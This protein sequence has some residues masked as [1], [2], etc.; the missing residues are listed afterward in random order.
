MWHR[1]GSDLTDW[2]QVVREIPIRKKKKKEGGGSEVDTQ[3]AKRV[4]E[5][6]QMS[7][8]RTSLGLRSRTDK[9]QVDKSRGYTEVVQPSGTPRGL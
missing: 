7:E 6:R 5:R 2:P 1:S 3:R 8:R 4:P 9:D